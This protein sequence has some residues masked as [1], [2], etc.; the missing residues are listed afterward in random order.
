MRKRLPEDASEFLAK[1]RES[2]E[3]VLVDVR[4]LLAG[5]FYPPYGDREIEG[6]FGRPVSSARKFV[7]T[8]LAGICGLH[9]NEAREAWALLPLDAQTKLD[10]SIDVAILEECAARGLQCPA[11][12]NGLRDGQATSHA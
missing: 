9:P 11:E 10:A 3:R 5:N 2:P 6:W 4:H 8:A 1:L 7:F 12:T